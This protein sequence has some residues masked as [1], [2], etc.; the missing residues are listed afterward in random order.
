MLKKWLSRVFTKTSLKA[1]SPPVP[2]L[3]VTVLAVSLAVTSTFQVT[4]PGCHGAGMLK[5]AQGLQAQITDMMQTDR[6]VPAG[7]C[8]DP[9]AE[10]TYIVTVTVTNPGSS[11]ISGNLTLNFY[12]PGD[13]PPQDGDNVVHSLTLGVAVPAGATKTYTR[14]CSLREFGAM[15]E[16]P[17]RAAVDSKTLKAEI[18]TPCTNCDGRGT[19]AFFD[20]LEGQ[21]K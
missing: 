18:D 12:D 10:Y 16:E 17:H 14:S 19:L 5:T 2:F 6:H 9:Y 15:L 21:A 7:C 13:S 1:A 3:V 4:C 11:T 20:W 8:D